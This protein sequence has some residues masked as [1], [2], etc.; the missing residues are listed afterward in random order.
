MCCQ[1]VLCA[2]HTHSPAPLACVWIILWVDQATFDLM[3]KY[4]RGSLYHTHTHTHTQLFL[5][6][7]SNGPINRNKRSLPV[8]ASSSETSQETVRRVRERRVIDERAAP[9]APFAAMN[10]SSYCLAGALPLFTTMAENVCGRGHI[11]QANTNCW[12]GLIYGR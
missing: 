6:C 8:A 1:G 5:Q 9:P 12:T 11:S 3:I 7:N 4:I 10:Q 2:W